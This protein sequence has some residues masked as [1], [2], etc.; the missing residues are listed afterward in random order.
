MTTNSESARTD[1]SVY[2]LSRHDKQLISAGAVCASALLGLLFFRSVFIGAAV[3]LLIPRLFKAFSKYFMVKRRQQLLI[4]FKDFLYSLSASM[5]TGRNMG[6]S[7]REALV[8]LKNIYD[9]N[10][11][12][13]Q[14]LSIIVSG[15]DNR[16]SEVYLLSDFAKRSACRDITGFTDVYLSVRESGGDMEKAISRT[17]EIL[18]DK[19]T[20]D[21]EIQGMLSQKKAEA[22]II[23]LMPVIILAGLNL[24]SSDYISPLYETL[25]G[26]L[27]MAGCLGAIGF[28][29]YLTERITDIK[30]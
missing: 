6:E 23:S 19:I 11:P 12:I 3:F 22:R 20:I 5:A 16:E 18:M 25:P 13:I 14:E 29:F 4:Q 10:A 26:R 7:I 21:R 8:N 28:A 9:N 30:V 27:I 1:Y 2:I 15:L 24:T 17:C